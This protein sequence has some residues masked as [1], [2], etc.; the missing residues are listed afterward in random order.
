MR[1]SASPL[2]LIL[3]GFGVFLLVL[4]P[5]LAWYV[6]P[7]A[8]RTPIDIDTTTVF[9]GK[10]RYFD[11]AALETKDDQSLTITR[12]VLGNVSESEKNDVAVWDV[13][14]TIDNPE[15][16][17][18]GDPRRSFL[19]TT[20]RWV[21]DRATNKPV[22]CCDEAPRRF[23]GDAYLKFPF[24]VEEKSYRWWDG[25]LKDTVPL[26]YQDRAKVQG[27]EGM[28][29]TGSVEPTRS[30]SRQV[31]G[32]LVGLPDRP[33]VNAEEWYANS[34]VELIVDERTGRILKASIGPRLTLRAPGSDKDAVVLL[35]SKRLSFD[36]KTQRTQVDL[37]S[38][39]SK[40]LEL[41]G[42]T[43]PAAGGIAG[44]LLAGVGAVLVA[45][46]RSRDTEARRDD[47]TRQ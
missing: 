20:E 6:E 15:T 8:K 14:T 25:T 36:T 45:R 12:R 16:L 7:R 19:W 27:Y 40:R 17:P 29:F 10:G 22:H 47:E 39:D 18:H 43:V 9:T 46:G 3:L 41:V 2:S 30:G 23:Q 24:G 34:G 42:E 38:A 1:R 33:Q 28:R 13:S 35:E 37:A 44:L 21:T 32:R 4:A 11:Q 5:M 31:P 26:R